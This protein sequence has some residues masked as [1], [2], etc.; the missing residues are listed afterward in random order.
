MSLTQENLTF[1]N[2]I[3]RFLAMHNEQGNAYFSSPLS[4]NTDLR[5]CLVVVIG[6]TRSTSAIPGL[7]KI[8]FVLTCPQATH[9]IMQMRQPGLQHKTLPSTRLILVLPRI[10]KRWSTNA[11]SCLAGAARFCSLPAATHSLKLSLN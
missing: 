5:R 3:L 9:L 11:I 10:S 6:F 2:T 4:S 8:K 7:N 1:I